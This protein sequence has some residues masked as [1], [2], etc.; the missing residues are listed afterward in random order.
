MIG[1]RAA[2]RDAVL[3]FAASRV[4]IWVTLGLEDGALHDSW[5][6]WDAGWYGDIAA[7]GYVRGYGGAF[8]DGAPAFFPACHGSS[9]RSASARASIP[10]SRER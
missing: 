5:H 3:A 6:R 9:A 1:W 7:R 2:I 4:L 8:D 10:S